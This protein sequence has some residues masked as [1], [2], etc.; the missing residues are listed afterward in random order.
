MEKYTER[1]LQLD[2]AVKAAMHIIWGIKFAQQTYSNPLHFHG[3]LKKK[4]NMSFEV[5]NHNGF[6][7]WGM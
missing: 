5:W 3:M 4:N 6:K 1:H 7:E 2:I